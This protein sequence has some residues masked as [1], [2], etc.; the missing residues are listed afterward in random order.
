MSSKHTYFSLFIAF[1]LFSQ[2]AV[3]QIITT[4][5][6][7]GYGAGTGSGDYTGNGGFATAARLNNCSGVAFD[8]AGNVYIAD[9]DNNVIRK[10][11]Y[12]GVI[13]N[14]AGTAVAGYNGDSLAATTAKLNSPYGVAVDV[15]GNVYIADYSNHRVRMV[16]TSGIIS[17]I[18]GTGAAGYS[19]DGGAATAAKLSYPQGIAVDQYG[20]VFVTES[21]NHVV[22]KISASG[23]ISTLAGNGTFGYS[24]NGG[25]A[26][27]AQLYG[28]SGVAVDVYGNIYIADY[29]NNVVR[30]VDSVGI[31]RNF[32]GNGTQ[33]NSGDGGA[34]VNAMLHN[35]SGVS[36][37]GHG[38][39]YISDQGN[40]NVR[41]VDDSGMIT[42]YAGTSTNGYIGDGAAALS[43]ELSSPKGLAVDG[44]GK[45]YVA[46]YDNNVI[47]LISSP[48]AVTQVTKATGLKVYPSPSN[49]SFTV[50]LAA[51]SGVATITV[52][53]MTGR[54]VATKTSDKTM[55]N[56]DLGS[57]SAGNYFVKANAGNKEYSAQVTIA[58]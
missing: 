29:Y 46:D 12:L 13:T 6:G 4:F 24:G 18:G 48:L 28:P 34:A 32:A 58:K 14:Y 1:A 51:T 53:D 21:G 37:Y 20:N 3:A 52:M 5:A 9:R 47:R 35:P 54:V 45:V 38:N 22:R 10:V 11:S 16:N 25:D 42:R 57:F 49:G 44:I 23:S 43:A 27:L 17:T 2:S 26:R 50:E 30:K 55:V 7:T 19:G 41:R 40:N 39:V 33:G 8:G 36:I 15:T 31:I 56:F